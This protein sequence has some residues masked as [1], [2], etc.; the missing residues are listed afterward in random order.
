MGFGA[1]VEG[2]GRTLAQGPGCVDR[3]AFLVA[4]QEREREATPSTHTCLCWGGVIET[5]LG[6]VFKEVG[7][8]WRKGVLST[9]GRV[10]G[11]CWEKL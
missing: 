11:L 2:F 10:V 8:P 7:A 1:G 6:Q 5:P 9:E 3:N 4:T